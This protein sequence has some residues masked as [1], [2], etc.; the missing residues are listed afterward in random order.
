MS[1][2]CK[3]RIMIYL[4]GFAITIFKYDSCVTTERRKLC[5]DANNT[6]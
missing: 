5:L 2:V 4:N 6:Q 3:N 1:L